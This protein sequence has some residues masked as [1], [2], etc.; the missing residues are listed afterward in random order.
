MKQA[1]LLFQEKVI[2][3][4]DLLSWLETHN[5]DRLISISNVGTLNLR[6]KCYNFVSQL[7]GLDLFPSN[8]WILPPG[9]VLQ[10]GSNGVSCMLIFTELLNS[11]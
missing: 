2:L 3:I 1:Y 8:P 7:N 5:Y 9:F 11:S 4:L 6:M 10:P